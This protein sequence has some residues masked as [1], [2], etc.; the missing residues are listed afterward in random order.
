MTFELST[1]F[2]TAEKTV[3]S[4]HSKIKEL[5]AEIQNERL[6]NQANDAKLQAKVNAHVSTEYRCVYCTVATDSDSL[7][8]QLSE[9]SAVK[10]QL[11]RAEEEHKQ[12]KTHSSAAS[13]GKLE[14]E[15]IQLRAQM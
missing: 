1:L 5:R 6:K 3:T 8:S 13:L 14:E 10:S 15:T 9:L 2:G 4:H 11:S 12:L 7:L